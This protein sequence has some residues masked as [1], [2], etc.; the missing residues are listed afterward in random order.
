[1]E[2]LP[3]VPPDCSLFN[4][5]I[6]RPCES[7]GRSFILTWVV[8]ACPPLNFFQTLG[9]GGGGGHTYS[10]L[11]TVWATIGLRCSVDYGATATR[12]RM[13]RGARHRIV[14]RE[15]VVYIEGGPCVRS[16]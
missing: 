15:R 11:C 7:A 4:S 6:I 8:L 2:K 10:V 14:W 9:G 5:Y 13:T 1:M 16:E 12:C 3:V